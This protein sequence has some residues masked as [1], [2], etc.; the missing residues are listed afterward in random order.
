MKRRG[1]EKEA[2][3]WG[4]NSKMYNSVHGWLF[5][6]CTENCQ[7]HVYESPKFLKCFIIIMIFISKKKK[8][9]MDFAPKLSYKKKA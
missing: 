8:N 1:G 3:K 2:G 4:D 9:T 7:I 5:V 6:P